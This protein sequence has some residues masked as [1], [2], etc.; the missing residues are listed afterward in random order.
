MDVL[1]T[2]DIDTT[3][4]SGAR[5]LAKVAHVCES[6]GT[7]VQ[8]SVFECQ[9][10]PIALQRLIDALRSKIDTQADSVHIYRFEGSLAAGRISLGRTI[11][12][13]LG[14]AWIV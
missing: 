3:T 2:Y 7:R 4:K 9:L 14:D 1:V 8:D 5:R 11:E 13:E 6:F 12:H 10:S